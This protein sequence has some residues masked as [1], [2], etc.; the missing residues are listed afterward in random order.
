MQ[1][2]LLA[3][4]DLTLVKTMEIAQSME[5]ADQNA[6]KLKLK[7]SKPN[8]QVSKILLG[9]TSKFCYHCGSDQHRPKDCRFRE[10]GC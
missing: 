4:N 1:K 7:G 3:K 6:Q 9:P 8:L 10:A 2:G 5:A